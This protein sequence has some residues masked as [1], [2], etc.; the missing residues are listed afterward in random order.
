MRLLCLFE[1]MGT[2]RGECAMSSLSSVRQALHI[3][4]ECTL[5]GVSTSFQ[6]VMRCI[7][8]STLHA[9]ECY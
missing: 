3:E 4:M 6:L 1:V 2:L 5:S 7:N 9:V 8:T